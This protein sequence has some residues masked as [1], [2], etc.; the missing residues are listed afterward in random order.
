MWTEEG[1]ER[2]TAEVVVRLEVAMGVARGRALAVPTSAP[3]N[4][5][6]HGEGEKSW[7]M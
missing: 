6:G 1:R 2:Q 3:G 7:V 5:D 4:R